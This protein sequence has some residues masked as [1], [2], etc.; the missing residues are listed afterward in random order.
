MKIIMTFP[1]VFA[2]FC[3]LFS[4]S[5]SAVKDFCVADFSAPEGPAGY[6]C[7]NPAKVTVDDFAYSGLGVAGNASGSIFKSAVATAFVDDFPGL[8]G[9]GV[10]MARADLAPGGVIPLHTHPGASEIL[11]AAEGTVTAGFISAANHVYIKTLNKGDIIV[12][13]QGL[14]HF[15]V[16]TGSSQALVFVSFSS[17]SPGVQFVS[18]ALFGNNFPTELITASTLLEASEV[19]RLKVVFNGSG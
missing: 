18:N 6:S 9:L 11:L 15:A 1:A 2:I 12:L 13:P 19:K 3:L 10:S 14:L 16:N 8:N 4:F 5:L 7:K 17:E